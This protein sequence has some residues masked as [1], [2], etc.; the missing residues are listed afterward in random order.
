MT[1]ERKTILVQGEKAVA[2]V[3]KMME[4]Q[5][6]FFGQHERLHAEMQGR[7]A[8]LI[9]ARN[10]DIIELTNELSLAL[11]LGEDVNHT[12]WFVDVMHFESHRIAFL[13]P[14]PDQVDTEV[15]QA[16]AERATM[17]RLDS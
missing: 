8:A 2:C 13:T 9:E 6:A 10:D 1:T 7:H 12:T 16:M 14:R 11:G 17:P 3:D 5:V 4:V 15:E